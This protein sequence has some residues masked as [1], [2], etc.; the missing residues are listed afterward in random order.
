MISIY[1]CSLDRL[2]MELILESSLEIKITELTK[3]IVSN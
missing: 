2:F 3:V 1:V